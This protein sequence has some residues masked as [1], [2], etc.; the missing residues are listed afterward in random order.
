M[1]FISH[2][3]IDKNIVNDFIDYI[4]YQ[5]LSIDKS[6]IVN[7]SDMKTGVPL[8]ESVFPTLKER[9]Y[10]SKF[11]LPFFS[12]D[13]FESEYCLYELG[14]AWIQGVRIIPVIIPPFTYKNLIEKSIFSDISSMLINDAIALD[15]LRDQIISVYS[16]G[17][18]RNTVEWSYAK[19]KFLKC[20][21]PFNKNNTRVRGKY[22]RFVCN[23]IEEE[24]KKEILDCLDE[25]ESFDESFK[26]SS[27]MVCTNCNDTDVEFEIEFEN[28]IQRNLL[29]SH[30]ITKSNLS[31]EIRSTF[32]M[33]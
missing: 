8:G 26:V 6:M 12:F 4:F 25:M 15:E 16:K 5:G 30:L 31:D 33:L 27:Y 24:Q 9:L 11:F 29:Y 13:Y 21:P 28:E 23:S 2:S 32:R 19:D 22:F 10:K 18:D 14:G 7:T 1:Y 20:L 3:S 17:V